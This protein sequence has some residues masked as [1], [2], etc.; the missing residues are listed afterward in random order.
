VILAQGVPDLPL[1][2]LLLGLEFPAIMAMLDCT[3]RPPEQFLG[4]APD[5]RSWLGWL[6]VSIVTVPI[7]LGYGI[8][9]GYYYA[10][11]RRNTPGL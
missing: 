10:V 5:R 4:G 1:P 6:A 8:L 3:F 11:I 9:I 7:L 2:L